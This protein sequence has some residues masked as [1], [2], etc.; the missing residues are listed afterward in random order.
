MFCFCL[1]LVWF[2]FCFVVVVVSTRRFEEKKA[3]L[4]GLSEQTAMSNSLQNKLFGKCTGP[5]STSL[6]V[7]VANSPIKFLTA[8]IARMLEVAAV[9]LDYHRGTKFR[10]GPAL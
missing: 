6:I 2:G 4:S 8:S 10:P 1:I 7:T 5:R 9:T 3:I